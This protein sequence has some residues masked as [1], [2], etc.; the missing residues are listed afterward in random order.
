MA[1]ALVATLLLAGCSSRPLAATA[2]PTR[3]SMPAWGWQPFHGELHWLN[4]TM[5]VTPLPSDAGVV[6]SPGEPFNCLLVRDPQEEQ[7]SYLGGVSVNLTWEA[8][9]GT[10]ELNLTVT[11][12]YGGTWST[13]GPSP[14]P[15]LVVMDDSQ[16]LRTPFRVDV[17]SALPVPVTAT[18]PVDVGVEVVVGLLESTFEVGWQHCQ[19]TDLP[20]IPPV[21]PAPEPGVPAPAHA[22]KG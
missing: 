8:G 6:A 1:L 4:A 20:P 9:P 13:Q 5:Q 11:G 2:E 22:H 14:L 12:L 18:V 15:L 21:A 19:A 10:D 3:P 17:R 7:A 16:N